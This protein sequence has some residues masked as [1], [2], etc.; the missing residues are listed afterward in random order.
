MISATSAIEVH[1]GPYGAVAEVRVEMTG[2]GDVVGFYRLATRI[3][4]ESGCATHRILHRHNGTWAGRLTLYC[5]PE[6]ACELRAD[7]DKMV[8]EGA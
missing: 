7:I 3:G 6:R 5:A 1:S 8:A 4:T 2:E